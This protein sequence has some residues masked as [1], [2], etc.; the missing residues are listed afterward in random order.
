MIQDI[1]P[2]KIN[3][4]YL[5]KTISNGDM[6]FIFDGDKVLCKDDGEIQFPLYGGIKDKNIEGGGTREDEEIDDIDNKYTY[7]FS[8]DDTNFFL[9]RQDKNVCIHSNCTNTK[10]PTSPLYNFTFTDINIFRTCKPKSLAFAG[11][12]A[13]HMYCW[14]KDNIFC[15]KCGGLL[16]H[17]TKERALKC[18]KCENLV[19]PKI[20]PAIIVG[21]IDGDKL[22]VTKYS[23]RIQAKYALVAG[24]MEIGESAEEAV[25][26]EVFEEVGVRVKNIRYYKSQPWGFSGSLLLG[27]FADLDGEADLTIDTGELS[28][29]VWLNRCEIPTVFEDF[30]LTNEMICVFK[31][32]R[33]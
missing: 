29:A 23:N 32:D 2:G 13:Y 28:E 6:V 3:I 11:I 21:I 26:R 18:G 7:L 16:T 24:F 19:Y 1:F 10:T 20:M 17:D 33:V 27:Y 12:T 15:G 25:K 9:S 30:S 4:E 8:V 5:H 14:Y 22:L 31:D